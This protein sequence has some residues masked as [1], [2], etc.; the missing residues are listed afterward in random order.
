[1]AG[2]TN[3]DLGKTGT[4]T[5]Y[6]G[7]Y[8]YTRRLN[9]PDEYTGN[10]PESIRRNVAAQLSIT[11]SVMDEL[12][13]QALTILDALDPRP[14]VA[15]LIA[16]SPRTAAPAIPSIAAARWV[17]PKPTDPVYPLGSYGWFHEQAA[18]IIAGRKNMAQVVAEIEASR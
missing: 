9:A 7:E 16:H 13:R 8:T 18:D 10:P 5:L 14:R 6:V 11:R 12:S 3:M 1:M 4:G 2:I 17:C 15:E